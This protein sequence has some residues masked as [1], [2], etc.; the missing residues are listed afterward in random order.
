MLLQL[1]EQRDLAENEIR[2][3]G[4]VQHRNIIQLVDSE[5]RVHQRGNSSSAYLL[6]PY[7]RVSGEFGG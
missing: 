6:F 4:L 1:P 7:Y 5:L 3:H 2:I